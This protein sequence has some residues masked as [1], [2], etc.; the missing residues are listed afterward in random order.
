MNAVYIYSMNRDVDIKKW[1]RRTHRGRRKSLLRA[2]VMNGE[3]LAERHGCIVDE[4]ETVLRQKNVPYHK[5]STGA[6][7]A[8]V[9][10]ER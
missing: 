8:S 3:Q 6:I 9:Y 10:L 4:L 2:T 1:R 5:D 7:W